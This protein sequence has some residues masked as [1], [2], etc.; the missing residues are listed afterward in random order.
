[1]VI[2][3][4]TDVKTISIIVKNK[5]FSYKWSY[6]FTGLTTGSRNLISQTV[7]VSGRRQIQ[8]NTN[9]VYKPGNASKSTYFMWREA[10]LLRDTN[11]IGTS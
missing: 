6:L 4:G 9:Y 5:Y 8:L 3:H 2:E 11:F 10:L 7:S 1:M